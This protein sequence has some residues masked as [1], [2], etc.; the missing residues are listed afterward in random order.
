MQKQFDLLAATKVSDQHG[1]SL[2]AT[3]KWRSVVTEAVEAAG[4]T[5]IPM[6]TEEDMR[7]MFTTLNKWVDENM[8]LNPT[9]D[10]GWHCDAVQC[11]EALIELGRYNASDA[12]SLGDTVCPALATDKCP[13]L[14]SGRSWVVGGIEDLTKLRYGALA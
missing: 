3:R 2:E 9:V 6:P 4:F 8:V 7:A 14:H 13:A 10:S 11:V 12:S 5:S 1:F